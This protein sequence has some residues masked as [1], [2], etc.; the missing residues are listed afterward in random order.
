MYIATSV[1][2]I[3][4]PRAGLEPARANAHRIL[5]PACLPIPPPRHTQVIKF[6]VI[7][8]LFARWRHAC[9]RLFTSTHPP[10]RHTQIT[11]GIVQ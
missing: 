2:T 11:S 5:S 8:D 4:V 6:I 7:A 9:Q 3:L 1:I 10:L